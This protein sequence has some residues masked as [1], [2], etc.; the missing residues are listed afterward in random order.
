MAA[1]AAERS[2]TLWPA[3]DSLRLLYLLQ[4]CNAAPM[5]MA[6]QSTSRQYGDLV[7]LQRKA[8]AEPEKFQH[9]LEARAAVQNLD[10]ALSEAQAGLASPA[11]GGLMAAPSTLQSSLGELVDLEKALRTEKWYVYRPD[12]ELK[13]GRLI[14]KKGTWLK[15]STRFSWE[16]AEQD[17]LYIPH[18][19]CMP[20]LQIGGINDPIELRR[21]EWAGQHQLVW[22]TPAVVRTLEARCGVWFI[23]G[24]HWEAL[25]NDVGGTEIVAAVDTWIKRSCQMSGELSPFEMMYVPEGLPLRLTCEPQDVEEE[26]EKNR[27][28]HVHQHRKICLATLPLTVKQD[29]YDICVGQSENPYR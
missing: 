15:K 29:K 28:Q 19:L 5:M 12:W 25:G 27:H 14:S 8:E 26:W 4:A 22:L 21:H 18:G 2:L 9:V 6:C 3:D 20:M 10:L 7:A 23:F 11:A 17:K 1:M 24:P 13:P 16:I